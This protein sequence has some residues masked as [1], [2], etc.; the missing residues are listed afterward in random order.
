MT[1][2]IKK[3]WNTIA[4]ILVIII[5]LL[6]IALAG[7]RLFGVKPYAVLSGS[8]E[9]T[10]HVGSLIYVKST[11]I[12]DLKVGDP[13]T[14]VLPDETVA[15]HRII[16]IT[17][18][19]NDPDKLAFETQGDANKLPDGEPVHEN[20][21]IGKPL[22]SIPLLG[23]LSHF[24]QNPPGLYISIA[25]GAVVLFIVFLPDILFDDKKNKKSK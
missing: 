1:T 14:F 7:V 15:T 20:N 21:I 2:K 22:F 13:I 25:I 8:M 18:D 10:Y 11:D 17:T 4:N 16:N 19:E 23:Y 9:P 5:V 24:I 12:K 3:I 6:A